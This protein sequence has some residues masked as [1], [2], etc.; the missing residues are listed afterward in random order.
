MNSIKNIKT[1]FRIA[2]LVSTLKIGGA[3]KQSSYLLN[4]LKDN[5]KVYLIVF[6]GDTIERKN[7]QLIR[8]HNYELILL[9]GNLLKKSFSFS[10]FLDHIELLIC[11]PI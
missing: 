10:I 1:S 6:H 8:G 11:F 4:A 5:Y 9:H 3:E 7:L 2:L